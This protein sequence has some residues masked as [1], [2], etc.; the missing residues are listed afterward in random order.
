LDEAMLRYLFD[1]KIRNVVLFT[2]LGLVSSDLL[3]ASLDDFQR[4]NPAA[5]GTDHVGRPLPDYVTGDECLFCHRGLTSWV[6]SRHRL[7]MREAEL[8]S[9]ALRALQNSPLRKFADGTTMVLGGKN[10]VRFLRP[11]GEYG[12]LAMLSTAWVP[13]RPGEPS[14]LD[15][16]ENPS[17][18]AAKFADSCAGCHATGVDPKTRAFSSPSLDCYICHGEAT[19][20]HSKDT[21]L[22]LLSRTRKDPARVV[23][24][25]CGSCHIRAG[26]SRSTRLPYPNN[27]VAGDNLFRDFDVDLS[28]EAIG[29]LNP[30]DRHVLEN[31][32][33]VAL[34]GK[35]ATTCLSCHTV[36]KDSSKKHREVVEQPLC[37]N[38]HNA[39]GPKSVRK[40]YE[41]RSTVCEY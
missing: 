26:R 40:A 4:L 22:M 15:R 3:K 34:L 31:V 14:H 33:D 18:D 28:D 10:R 35:D 1:K 7:T 32:R 25:I 23:I 21:S 30:A 38:C 39:T 17:W 12:K 5:W 16:T 37:L 9:A 6:T 24:S 13:P 8:D 36:H 27:F 20:D 19:L 11:T 29:R 41:V 2:A